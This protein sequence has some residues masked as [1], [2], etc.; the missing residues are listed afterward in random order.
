MNTNKLNLSSPQATSGSGY[1]FETKVQ[2]VFTLSF[3]VKGEVPCLTD[4]EIKSLCFQGKQYGYF[5]DDIIVKGRD[6][7]TNIEKKL[8]VQI[9]QSISFTK[10]NKKFMG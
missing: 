4:C 7:F 2:A 9:K 1:K 5:V 8:L 6:K 10:S 3:L